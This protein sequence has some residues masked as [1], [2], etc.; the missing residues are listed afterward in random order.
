M[1]VFLNYCDA[2]TG[3]SFTALLDKALTDCGISTTFSLTQQK[4]PP[5]PRD[6]EKAI[7]EC[8]VFIAVFS[9]NYA[10]S[11][12]SLDNLSYVL[13]LPRR[14]TILPVFYD[15]DP[16]HVRWQNGPFERAFEDHK[17]K[18]TMQGWRNALKEV[19]DLS[20]WVNKDYRVEAKLVRKLV[21]H[22][23]TNLERKAPMHIADHPVGLESRIADVMGL[24]DID[25]VESRI[26]GIHG[27]GGI[28]KTTLAKAVYN[29]IRSSFQG[30]CFLSDVRESSKTNNGVVDLQK[31][32]L[33]ELFNESEPSIYNVDG[34]INVIKNRIGSKKVLVIIDDVDSE[35]QL[36][37][38]AINRDGYHKGSRIIITARDEHVLN[39]KK[40]VD[41][42]HI[43]KLK[44]LDGTESL[45]LFCW[46]AFG[47]DEPKQEYANLSK[48]VV[49][50]VDGLPL[51]LEVLGSFLFDKTLEEWDEAV[52]NLKPISE[53]DVIPTLKISFDDLNEETKQVFLD[54]ACF[55]IGQDRDYTINIWK[56]CGFPPLLT[57][58]KLLQRSLIKIT[59]KN[60]LW[61]H[62]QLRDMGRRIV[63]LENLDAPGERSRL[64][65]E[66]EVIDV[67]KNNKGTKKVRG[68]NILDT[69][70]IE[71]QAFKSMTN[72]KLLD[73]C[74][75]SLNGSFK[76]ISSELVWL[77]WQGC[78]LQYLLLDGFSHEKL[79]ILDFSFSD[80][81]LD[82]SNNNVKPLFPK[83]QSLHL[84]NC[85][86]L[87]GIPDCSLY[88]NL[89]KLMLAQCL[90]LKE[91]PDSLG[92]LAKLKE[93]DVDQCPNLIRFPPSMRRMRSLRYLRMASVAIATLPDDF[94]RLSNL[95]ELDMSWCSRLKELPKNFGSLTS[96]RILKIRNINLILSTLSGCSSLEELDASDCNLEGLKP[97]DFEKLSSLKVLNLLEID[98]QGLPISL[99]GLSQLE[100]LCVPSCKQLVAIPELP[101]GLKALDASGCESLQTIPN[102]SHLSKLEHLNI[103]DCEQLVA[104]PELP[105]SL[106]HLATC[107]CKSVRKILNLSHLSNLER[108]YVSNCE[109]LSAIQDLPTNLKILMASKCISLETIPKLSLI[110]KLE[111][112][113]VSNCKKLSAIQDL[114]TNLKILNASECV[115]LELIPNLSHLSKLEKLDVSDCEKLSAIEDLPTTLEFLKASNCRSLETIPKLSHLSKLQHLDVSD[116]EKLLAI[117][118]LPTTL[119][120]LKASNCRSLETIPKLAHLS[121]LQDLDVSDCEKLLAIEDLPTTLKILKA[122]NCIRLV[123]IS[124]LSHHSQLEEFD[125]RNCKRMTK[126]QGVGGLKCLRKLYL[127]GCSP[128]VWRGQ[129]L[130]KEMFTSLVQLSVPGSKVP[131]WFACKCT[132]RCSLIQDGEMLQQVSCALPRPSHAG[133]RI[134]EI[135][136]CLVIYVHHSSYTRN[137]HVVGLWIKREDETLPQIPLQIYPVT[138]LNQNEIYFYRFREG[139]YY[140]NRKFWLEDGDE[141][142]VEYDPIQCRCQAADVDEP[143]EC[144]D[145]VEDIE[146][147]RASSLRLPC[148]RLK[149]VGIHFIY[150]SEDTEDSTEEK[151]ANFFNSL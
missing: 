142:E 65:S 5:P 149:K 141:I 128:H 41:E 54:I 101:T 48:D 118:D 84:N 12:S 135:M 109:K 95:E 63:E 60:E 34:G 145:Q 131:N 43:Y 120:I 134:K 121:K 82:L 24:L 53:K 32:L 148:V 75:A 40:R 150:E 123:I 13:S 87:E 45:Q 70:E 80:F 74:D 31:Q 18:K 42:S 33:K 112:L 115:S 59:D 17:N 22:V 117:E 93:L 19:A 98:F 62:D 4:P 46:C 78:P 76:Y 86:N 28:G 105:T 132:P 72:L 108:L 9:P 16:Y 79:V 96:L 44:E 1:A 6:T 130:A 143:T 81:V 69:I 14:R 36:E 102:L 64:W 122:S 119:K 91:L 100:I 3:K 146:E 11:V 133:R 15:V 10:F 68:I 92:S 106:N 51:A 126:I 103:N 8:E 127:S 20:G 55:F 57:I 73:I 144:E 137:R 47:M 49:S 71:T 30:S 39:V 23:S 83:L 29:K 125:L 110:S 88:P 26:I 67:L 129:N 58:R 50:T 25:N 111:H 147:L 35:K 114:P 138:N 124:N 56:G 104:V 136:V 38:L 107:G 61:M 140:G 89:E 116:C 97:D 90:K 113:D 85:D 99:R 37:N 2:D 66:E 77:R 139:Q 94:G 7:G 21:K 52:K 27:M 151:L